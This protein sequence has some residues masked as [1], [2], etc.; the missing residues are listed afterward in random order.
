[1]NYRLLPGPY[2]LLICC[3]FLLFFFSFVNFLFSSGPDFGMSIRMSMKCKRA[4]TKIYSW[5]ITKTLN[6]FKD[7]RVCCTLSLSATSLSL[8]VLCDSDHPFKK[9]KINGQSRRPET[10]FRFW[11][12]KFKRGRNQTSTKIQTE[13]KIIT[14]TASASAYFMQ[15]ELE[16]TR[17]QTTTSKKKRIKQLTNDVPRMM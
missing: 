3:R 2:L 11:S 17:Q 10:N 5:F 16:N 14:E 12:T 15:N 1:M 4:E 9:K 8:S 6:A 13:P 7:Y